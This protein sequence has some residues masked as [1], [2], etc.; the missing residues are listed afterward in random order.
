VLPPTAMPQSW[1]V[2]PSRRDDAA[3]VSSD[4]AEEV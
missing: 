2:E 1:K 4:I 3:C